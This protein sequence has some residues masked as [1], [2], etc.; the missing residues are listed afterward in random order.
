MV[1]NPNMQNNPNIHNAMNPYIYPQ[2]Y[3]KTQQNMDYKY[4]NENDQNE[5]DMNMNKNEDHQQSYEG[6]QQM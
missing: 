4:Q 2:M 3:Y 1:V 6:D 5:M